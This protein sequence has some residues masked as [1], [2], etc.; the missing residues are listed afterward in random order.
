M[1]QEARVVGVKYHTPSP[2]PAGEEVLQPGIPQRPDTDAHLHE[3]PERVERAV[4]QQ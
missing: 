1:L 2:S 4:Q 3:A